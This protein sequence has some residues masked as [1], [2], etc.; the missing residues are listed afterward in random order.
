MRYVEERYG[1]NG[2]RPQFSFLLWLSGPQLGRQGHDN[3]TSWETFRMSEVPFTVTF[4]QG[5]LLAS[6]EWW[7]EMLLNVLQGTGSTQVT[8]HPE[9]HVLCSQLSI[10]HS[11]VHS[12]WTSSVCWVLG[13]R[14]I[15]RE[16]AFAPRTP[17]LYAYLQGQ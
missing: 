16:K 4:V 5:V 1:W 9:T 12:A 10:S 15:K 7:P 2:R 17:H 8:C 11:S 13:Y 3:F 14:H 6:S